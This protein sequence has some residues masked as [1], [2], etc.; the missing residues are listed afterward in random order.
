MNRR[1]YSMTAPQ[2]YAQAVAALNTLQSNA[3]TVSLI[4]KHGRGAANQ[5]AIPEAIELLKRTGL[6]PAD[7]NACNPIH[8][9]GTKGKGS[10]SAF[11]ASILS[12]YAKSSSG[13]APTKIGLYTSPHL[14]F[15]R[16]RIQIDGSP[17]SEETFAN[18][19]GTTWDKLKG[20]T[21]PMP[22]YFR[23]LTLMAFQTFL[24]EKVDSAVIECGIGGEYDTTNVLTGPTVTAITALGIDHE[25]LLGNTIDSIAWHKAGIFKP[26]AIALT[27]PQPEEAMTVLYK[28][29]EEKKVELHVIKSHPEIESGQVELGVGGVFQRSNASLAAV[30]ASAQLRK[31]GNLDVPDL[32]AHYDAPLPEQFKTGLKS[33]K[34]PGRCD[35]RKDTK[36][37]TTWYLDGAHTMES[38]QLAAK[39]FADK[40][41]DNSEPE[42]R[43]LIFNQQS[44][45][46]KQLANGLL[47]IVEPQLSAT[48]FGKVI[49]TTNITTQQG[50]Y[51]PDLVSLNND[52]GQVQDLHVQR[53]IGSFWESID[54]KAKV[55]ITPTIEEA[56]NLARAYSPEAHVLIV[57]SLHLVGGAIDI[58]ESD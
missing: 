3:A 30:I 17:L 38:I 52:A 25:A 50:G 34:W 56:I 4:R 47:K 21:G 26:G 54:G 18:Y 49:F 48:P 12:E 15:V 11:V 33:V 22:M 27:V 46:A 36:S 35:I 40:V 19:F 32:I 58:L 5:L 23:F 55:D 1:F 16:E 51:K 45:D 41:V 14:R 2:T 9:A 24:S 10:T 31:L 37:D 6:E 28:R 7:I 8:I 42:N 44:R 29:A 53:D 13:N 39:W 43:V 57:G 20:S